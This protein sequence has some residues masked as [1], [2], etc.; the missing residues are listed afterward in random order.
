MPRNPRIDEPDLV[1]HVI[2]RGIER[3]EIFKS[4]SDRDFFMAKLGKLALETG[5]QL[6]AYTLMPNHFHLLLRRRSTP[7]ATFMQRMLTAYAIYF[8][9][10]YG[11][12][13]HLFQNRYRSFLCRED[14]YFLELIRYIH[15]NPLRGGIIKSLDDLSKYPYSSHKVIMGARGSNWYDPALIL[16][17]FGSQKEYLDFVAAGI[18]LNSDDIAAIKSSLTAQSDK[19]WNMLSNSSSMQPP[20]TGISLDA[21]I[22]E[23]CA[24]HAI[25]MQELLGNSRKRKVANARAL[26]AYRMSSQLG[27][28]GSE[29]GRNLAVTR[30]AASKMIIKGVGLHAGDARDKGM[31]TEDGLSAS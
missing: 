14:M 22:E 4:N 18:D 26:L 30:S 13:G 31:K 15:L 17:H 20:S 9:K 28:T 24:A 11:R 25:S 19:E 6:Y 27:L 16:A 3:R 5:T 8:N 10:K 1:Y 7:T 23:T 21:L 12:A 2:A 29:I